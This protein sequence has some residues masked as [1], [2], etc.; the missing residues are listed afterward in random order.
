MGDTLEAL[1]SDRI[2][3]PLGM[4]RT[5]F[6]FDAKARRNYSHGHDTES[7]PDKWELKFATAGRPLHGSSGGP[8]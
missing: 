5:S 4:K 7:T 3:A 2:F 8:Y 1:A 6:V